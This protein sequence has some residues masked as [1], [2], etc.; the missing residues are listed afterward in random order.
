MQPGR[1]LCHDAP[2]AAVCSCTHAPHA[3]LHPKLWRAQGAVQ[4]AASGQRDYA[5][6]LGMR[7]LILAML[8]TCAPGTPTHSLNLQLI[9]QCTRA[10]LGRKA[11]MAALEQNSQT[12][13]RLPLPPKGRNAGRVVPDHAPAEVGHV[14]KPGLS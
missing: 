6:H 5:Q 4:D 12:E 2:I 8:P 9:Q 1:Q 7:Q 10:A 14:T 13:S 11:C 3:T